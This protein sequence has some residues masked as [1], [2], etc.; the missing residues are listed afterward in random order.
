M[1][2]RKSLEKGEKRQEG[3]QDDWEIRTARRGNGGQAGLEIPDGRRAEKQIV[4][5]Y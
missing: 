4:C 5:K 3:A 2:I 1:K